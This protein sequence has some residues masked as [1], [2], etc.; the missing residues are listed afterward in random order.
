ML[1]RTDM[2][3]L[4][5][6]RDALAAERPIA[7]HDAQALDGTA[8]FAAAAPVPHLGWTV[9]IEQPRREALAPVWR[10]LGQSAALTGIGMLLAVVASTWL[11]RRLVQPIR[12]LQMRA[13]DIAAGRLDQ[14]IELDSGDELQAL[15]EQFNRMTA[16]LQ[17]IYASLESRVA[18]R[19]LALAEANEAKS[20]FLAAASHDLRQPVHAL[21]L[22]VGQ[23][24]QAGDD[25]TRRAL[26]A[27]IERAV[28]AFE[29]LLESLLD[30]SRL[31]AGTVAVRREPVALEPLLDRLAASF[32]PQ[33]A[34]RGLR[35]RVRTR[36]LWV[37][38]DPVLLERV[39]LNL[40][41]NALRY[42]QRGGVL[43]GTRRRDG[44]VE[45]V[46]A[47][48][49]IGIAPEQQPRVFQEFYRVPGATAG[50]EAG[51]GL[52]LAIVRRLAASARP[53]T[54]VAVGTWQGQLLSAHAAMVPPPAQPAAALL[55][56]E[57][58]AGRR[59]LVI[60]DDSTVREAT[61]GQIAQWGCH[62]SVAS[63]GVQALAR[64]RAD[65]P[66]LVITDLQL[67]DGE[68]GLAL[69]IRLR[70]AGAGRVVV[71]TADT[72]PA[73]WQAVRDAGFTVLAKPLRPA[74]L[75]ALLEALLPPV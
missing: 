32:A 37:D 69:A 51:L 5:H 19:T 72:S 70:E 13:A 7:M 34:A 64:W 28:A 74:K 14:R 59:V 58:L 16:N 71:V 4:A 65:H 15:G 17:G 41:G 61:R 45:L 49:G 55:P 39:L 54:G 73:R 20:R 52:G 43:V 26:V 68:D 75:R 50:S 57:P 27:H 33:A 44:Q 1:R 6:V 9:L 8:V 67:A 21:G 48:T 3:G 35:L 38:S 23:L 47:D 31:D 30:I 2:G 56:A 22:F 46:V 12:A 36:D 42:T 40:M 66:E 11:A 53:R 63:D 29:T 18:E 25:A 60:D 10:A 24:R 62:V